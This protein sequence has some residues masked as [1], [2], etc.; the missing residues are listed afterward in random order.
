LSH[1][2]VTWNVDLLRTCAETNGYLR[3]ST[4][5]LFQILKAHFSKTGTCKNLDWIT[6]KGLF[7][8]FLRFYSVHFCI[9]LLADRCSF[10]HHSCGWE[11][12]Q[13]EQNLTS[14]RNAG[15]FY[16]YSNFMYVR[17]C[18]VNQRASH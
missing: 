4:T 7:S 12:I 6:L 18:L 9:F 17:H 1:G 8:V 3:G 5:V 10:V 2:V 11:S 14:P 16:G 15:Q 13:A